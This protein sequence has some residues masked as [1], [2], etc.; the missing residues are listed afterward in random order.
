MKKLSIIVPFLNEQNTIETILNEVIWV[1]L[2]I[3]WY[4]K[5]I[6]LI[7]DG[8]NDNS[9]NII[10]N[11]ILN[12]KELN[13]K[14]IKNDR[15]YWKWYSIKRWFNQSTWDLLIIQD[16][17]MEYNPKDYIE[18]IKKIEKDNLDIVYWS[19]ILWI[20]E[21]NNTY[22]TKSFLLWGLLVS[23]LTSLLS[24]T[25]VTDEPTCYKLYKKDLKELLLRPAENW[26]EWE[27][28]VT[29]LLLKNWF[30]YWEHPINYKARKVTEWKKIK[31]KDW[32]IALYTLLIRRFKN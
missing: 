20:K 15:N 2:N 17:D 10:L 13:I 16:A 14:Y 24:F 19:R 6:I 11:F 7:N 1:D 8:S 27:P 25:K 5:E 9:E 32:I 31:W 12:N 23:I 29:M 22:S 28:A 3:I 18:L 26:F 4:E 21:F 30:K